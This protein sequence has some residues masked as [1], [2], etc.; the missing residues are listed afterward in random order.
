MADDSRAAPPDPSI[1]T[2]VPQA[3]AANA[4]RRFR[5]LGLVTIVL[6]IGAGIYWLTTRNLESTDNAVIDGNVVQI[7]PKVSGTVLALHVNDN[8]VVK[9]G[10]PLLTIDPRDYEVAVAS[11]TA[12]LANATAQAE[13]TRVNLKYAR[14]TISASLDQAE[15]GVNNARA[16]L[17][18]AQ[19]QVGVAEAEAQRATADL[20]RYERLVGTDFASKQ[21][22]EQAQSDARTTAARLRAAQQGVRA[23]DAQLSQALGKLD[24]AKTVP[25]QVAIREAELKAAEAQVL[26]ASATLQQAQLNLSYTKLLAPQDGIVTRRKVNAGDQIDKGQNLFALVVGQP[27]I[28][29]NFKET[30]LTRM[31]PGQ[32]VTVTIDAYPSRTFKGHVDS[33]QRGT[34]ARFALLPPENATG[35]FIKVVQRVPVKIV[36]DETPDTAMALGLGMSVV[37]TVNVAAGQ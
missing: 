5:I 26:A 15:A 34:G 20:T 10:D 25:E 27:W 6:A 23:S 17:S 4:R 21:R 3:N 31:R 1:T 32:P 19:A 28:T 36:F 7:G 11:A 35:N 12:G 18:Q 14:T 8:Q 29:A 13:R 24:E 37:P 16:A 9:A 30:Q 22:Y 2:S 33:I